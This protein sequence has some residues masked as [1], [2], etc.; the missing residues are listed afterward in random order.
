MTQSETLLLPLSA[1]RAI[2]NDRGTYRF[3]ADRRSSGQLK[4]FNI[5]GLSVVFFVSG[6]TKAQLPVVSA[7]EPSE[8]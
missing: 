8:N 2:K 5:Q 3:V 7:F 1:W 6:V 4:S